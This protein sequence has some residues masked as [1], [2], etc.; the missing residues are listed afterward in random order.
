M[1]RQVKKPATYL[2]MANQMVDQRKVGEVVRTENTCD[3]GHV[4]E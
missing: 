2:L 1:W 3:R 4:R